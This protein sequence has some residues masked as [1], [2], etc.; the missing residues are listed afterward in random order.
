MYIYNYVHI[1]LFSVLAGYILAYNA[2]EYEFDVNV[3]SPIGTVAFYA[4]LVAENINNFIEI[5]INFIG[6][7]SQTGPYSINGRS[8][9]IVFNFPISTNPLLTICLNETL[10]S[11]DE[12]EDYNFTMVYLGR[13]LE[14]ALA[15]SGSANI[16]LHEISK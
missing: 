1:L 9:P 2:T 6:D 12:Q 16:I 11:T 5:S 10:N 7:Q 14:G 3:Y 8:V 15:V 4:L 13:P